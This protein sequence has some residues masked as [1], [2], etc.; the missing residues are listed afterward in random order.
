MEVL[1]VMICEDYK[2]FWQS[3]ALKVELNF[4]VQ[5]LKHYDSPLDPNVSKFW[6]LSVIKCY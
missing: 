2:A 1:K 6:D 4:V 5:T 3:I